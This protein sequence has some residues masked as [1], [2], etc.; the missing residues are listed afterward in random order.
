LDTEEGAIGAEDPCAMPGES[1]LDV[2]MSGL[3]FGNLHEIFDDVL[4]SGM[5]RA[6]PNI[7]TEP[8]RQ[9]E[10]SFR[11]FRLHDIFWSVSDDVKVQVPI[12]LE[13]VDHEGV[14]NTIL[15]LEPAKELVRLAFVMTDNIGVSNRQRTN[16]QSDEFRELEGF[17]DLEVPFFD[18]SQAVAFADLAENIVAGEWT[19]SS[20]PA[21]LADIHNTEARATREPQDSSV[22][23]LG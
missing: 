23:E 14:S 10:P 6:A 22:W 9:L 8:T 2:A 7:N 11:D 13:F 1:V 20:G 4:H 17:D 12:A 15:P 3:E 16:S 18:T 21:V 19:E 5:R